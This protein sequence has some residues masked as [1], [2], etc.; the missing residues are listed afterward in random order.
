MNATCEGDRR[1][2]LQIL[3]SFC[4]ASGVS[5]FFLLIFKLMCGGPVRDKRLERIADMVC[6]IVHDHLPCK[7]VYIM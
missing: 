3:H 4:G 6:S 5:Y 7:I 2:V 1:M